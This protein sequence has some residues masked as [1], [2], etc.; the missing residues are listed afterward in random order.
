VRILPAVLVALAVPFAFVYGC[1]GSVSH[2]S[3]GASDAA[4]EGATFAPDSGI[5]SSPPHPEAGLDAAPDGDGY[6]N[7][8]P[9]CVRTDAGVPEAFD[10]GAGAED[11]T[12]E[13]FGQLD[14]LLAELR[15]ES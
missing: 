10:A 13:P 12:H 15:L 14:D 3:G 5:D 9:H 7:Q 4:P 1:G 11:A 8:A 2:S 6:K